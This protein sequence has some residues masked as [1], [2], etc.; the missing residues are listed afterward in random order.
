MS[1]DHLEDPGE[2]PPRERAGNHPMGQDPAAKHTRPPRDSGWRWRLVITAILGA[3]LAAVM[4]IGLALYGTRQ[5]DDKQDAQAELV[6]LAEA[7][8][9]A[10]RRFGTVEAEKVLGAGKC[11]QTK[12]IV[13][14]P[15][16]EKGEPGARGPVGPQGPAGP[17][18]PRGPSGPAGANGVSPGCLILVSKCQGAEGPRGFP[19]LTGPPGAAGEAGPAGPAGEQGPKGEAGDQG[20]KGDQGDQGPEGPQGPPGPAGPAC[21][22]GSTLQTRHVNTSEEPTGTAVLVCVLDTPPTPTARR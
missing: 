16:A 21:P 5:K 10:C 19:G 8:Q 13:E 6:G 14:R 18:G 15:P 22:T 11:Q 20:P 2:Q 1:N 9:A 12:E 4:L 3:I 17:Q 7:N